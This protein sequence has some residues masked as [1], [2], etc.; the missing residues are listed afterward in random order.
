M[1]H[2][3]TMQDVAN[4]AG[5]SLTTVSRV[6]NNHKSV[7]PDKRERVNRAIEQ[8]GFNRSY[9]ARSLATKKSG[10]I[11]VVVPD[12]SYAFYAQML[13]GIEDY[14]SN[15]AYSIIICNIEEKLGKEMHYLTLFAEMRVNGIVMMHEKLDEKIARFMMDCGIPVVLASVRPKLLAGKLSS[16]NIDDFRASYEGT[17]HLIR[18]NRRRIALIAGNLSDATSGEA[19]YEGYKAALKDYGIEEDD[20]LIRFGKF[21]VEDGYRLT[22]DIFQVSPRRPDALFAVGDILAV[23]ALRYLAEA[24]VQVPQEVSVLGFDDLPIATMCTP[25]LSTIRQPIKEIG[26]A[27]VQTLIK[28]MGDSSKIIREVILKHEI[29][30]RESV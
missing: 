23:G 17:E 2:I 11:G 13:C 22:R 14:A 7:L 6:L 30:E 5:V 1:K 18:R 8:L 9:I 3:A 16:V 24:K 12:I 25:R 21:S 28:S 19:R 10:L 4:Q 27:A 20:A 29:V 26:V 15:N